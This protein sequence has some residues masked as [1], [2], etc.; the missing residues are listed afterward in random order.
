VRDKLRDLRR[1]LGN[2][3]HTA[4]RYTLRL[5]V[6]DWLACGLADRSPNSIGSYST[7]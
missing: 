3:L 6:G 2:G 4:P 7:T 5:A 1:E